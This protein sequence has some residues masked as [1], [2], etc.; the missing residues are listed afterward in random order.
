MSGKKQRPIMDR[1]LNPIEYE[2]PRSDYV[3]P[4]DEL[5]RIFLGDD[6]KSITSLSCCFYTKE[7]WNMIFK[8][9]HMYAVVQKRE[10]AYSVMGEVLAGAGMIDPKLGMAYMSQCLEMTKGIGRS[11]NHIQLYLRPSKYV[12]FHYSD[13]YKV[14][15]KAIRDLPMRCGWMIAETLIGYNIWT[16]DDIPE[17]WRE[18]YVIRNEIREEL[19]RTELLRKHEKLHQEFLK[20]K[21][22]STKEA[23][24]VEYGNV[25][26]WTEENKN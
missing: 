14:I 1:L 20:A 10:S 4:V 7:F 11:N 5:D 6:P 24:N 25:K 19:K 3:E 15:G 16:E 22:R 23:I 26:Y 17:K 9:Y 13:V 18:N 21:N 8:K 12:Q 2:I